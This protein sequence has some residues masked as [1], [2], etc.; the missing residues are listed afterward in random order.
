MIRFDKNELSGSFGD[1]GT[2]FPLIIGLI[3]ACKLDAASVMIMFGLMQIMT[4]LIYGIPMSVQPLKAM[5]VMMIAQK[6]EGTLLYGAGLAIGATMLLLT[7]TGLLEWI[8]KVIPE[9]VIRGIQFGLGVSLAGL[10][11]KDY[12]QSDGYYGYM[13]AFIAFAIGL[14][15][16]GNRKYPPALFIM[17]LAVIYAIIF[18]INIFKINEGIGFALPT[19]NV[20][21]KDDIVQGFIMLAIPQIALSL[22]NS[23]VATRQTVADLFPE[24]KLTVRKIG[25]TYSLMNVVNPF[26]SG[27]PACHGSGGIAGHYTFGARTGGS[28]IIYGGLC[29]VIGLFFST[30]FDEIVKVFPLPVLGIILLFESLTLMSF[31]RSIMHSKSDLLIALLVAMI[32]VGLPHG[33]VI[34]LVLGTFAV[35]LFRRQL[36]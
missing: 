25:F 6:L 23:V 33:Y 1:I 3:L 21:Q 22:S 30:V 20:P 11:L 19:W 34:G 13:I 27:L 2:S 7:I 10:A 5:A 18:K 32:A 24:K 4:G 35:M 31:I 28:V 9:C 12:V 16:L 17:S 15:L 26:F 36:L 14:F 8:V 29:L